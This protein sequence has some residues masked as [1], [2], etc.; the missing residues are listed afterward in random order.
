MLTSANAISG[1]RR[2]VGC[3]APSPW[4]PAECSPWPPLLASDLGQ[5][6]LLQAAARSCPC[7]GSPS[8]LHIVQRVSWHCTPNQ[9]MQCQMGVSAQ[10]HQA[11]ARARDNIT[12]LLQTRQAVHF[13][14]L[15]CWAAATPCAA[16][17]A[18]AASRRRLQAPAAACLAPRC[19]HAPCG[20]A[21]SRLAPGL[22]APSKQNRSQMAGT[23]LALGGL[24]KSYMHMCMHAPRH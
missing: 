9:H 20:S 2:Q 8:H 12:I 6:H 23:E 1:V 14:H 11:R 13:Q 16:A 21:A 22:P 3:G 18:A 19:G 4:S 7:L 24:A 5:N 17:A 15:S 10:H